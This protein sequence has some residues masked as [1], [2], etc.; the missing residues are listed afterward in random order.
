MGLSSLDVSCERL[1]RVVT[2]PFLVFGLWVIW[3]ARLS[4]RVGGVPRSRVGSFL[5]L[6]GWFRPVRVLAGSVGG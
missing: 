1:G 2:R 3:V 6:S 5:A 4:R